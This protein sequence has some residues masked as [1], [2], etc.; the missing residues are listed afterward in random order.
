M[1]LVS[2][3]L[4]GFNTRYDCTNC[5]DERVK[6]LVLSGKALPV[7]PEQ[8]GWLTTPRPPVEFSSGDGA[9]ILDSWL[10]GEKK[11]FIRVFCCIA[12][13]KPGPVDDAF[14]TEALIKGAKETLRLARAYGIKKAIFKDG[15]PSCGAGYVHSDGQRRPGKGVTAALLMREG[16][17]VAGVDYLQG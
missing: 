4:A 10:D 12:G 2:A 15:S 17:E 6:K 13:G 3:C 5:L 11:I 7:C 9:S 1:Y 16:I 14:I 8:L